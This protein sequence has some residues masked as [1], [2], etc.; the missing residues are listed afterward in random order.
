MLDPKVALYPVSVDCLTL[1]FR[2]LVSVKNHICL[3]GTG[4][5]NFDV[6]YAGGKV[7]LVRGIKGITLEHPGAIHIRFTH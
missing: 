7:E 6:L 3:C 2:Q 5:C 1:N 4:T